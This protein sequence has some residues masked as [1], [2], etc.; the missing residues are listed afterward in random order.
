MTSAAIDSTDVPPVHNIVGVACSAALLTLL[1][2][3]A[4]QFGY[5]PH[6][7]DPPGR[8]FDSDRITESEAAHPFGL[9]DGL[10]GLASYSM[11][12]ALALYA[13]KSPQLR[14]ALALKLVL[15][16]SL[17]SFNIVRQVVSF[18][19]LCSWCTGTALCTAVMLISERGTI[20]QQIS[21]TM[22]NK[23]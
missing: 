19:R 16:G 17:A 12:L 14:R 4:H 1:P 20:R 21:T 6:L 11:T 8:A 18:R 15:D 22:Q 3:S 5:L 2:V 23:I 9:P 13:S 10:L 7:P